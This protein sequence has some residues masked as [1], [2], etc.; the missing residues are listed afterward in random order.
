MFLLGERSVH[1]R[2]ILPGFPARGREPQYMEAVSD[3]G[4]LGASSTAEDKRKLGTLFRIFSRRYGEDA[5]DHIQASRDWSIL[6][7]VARHPLQ[8]EI[9]FWRD[10]PPTKGYVHISCR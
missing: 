9:H 3:L 4:D 7:L 5:P 10:E 8:S 2:A 6:E 1:F